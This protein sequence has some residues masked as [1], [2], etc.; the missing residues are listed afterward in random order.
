[1]L[2]DR[3]DDTGWESWLHL[4]VSVSPWRDGELDPL[5]RLVADDETAGVIIAPPDLTGSITLM[6]AGRT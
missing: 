2:T 5:L 6:T 4:Y 1:M 3:D